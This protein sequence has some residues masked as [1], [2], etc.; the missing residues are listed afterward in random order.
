MLDFK[1]SVLEDTHGSDH[2]PILLNAELLDDEDTSERFNFKKADWDSYSEN[3]RGRI[4]EDSIFDQGSCPV[5]SITHVLSDIAEV[6]V[7]FQLCKM[8][9]G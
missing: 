3:C 1:W 5:E 9:K 8:L 2:Y 4:R 6:I 7:R